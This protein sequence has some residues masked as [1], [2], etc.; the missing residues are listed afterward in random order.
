M[1][2]QSTSSSQPVVNTSHT[3]NV[4]H[5]SQ[6]AYIKPQQQPDGHLRAGD[7]ELAASS[8]ARPCVGHP[9]N[10]KQARINQGQ[11]AL[12]AMMPRSL[13][14]WCGFF[15]PTVSIDSGNARPHDGC[16]VPPE[17]ALVYHINHDMFKKEAQTLYEQQ[18]EELYEND[19][20][21]QRKLPKRTIALPRTSQHPRYFQRQQDHRPPS[22]HHPI[23]NE[24][25]MRRIDRPDSEHQSQS[26]AWVEH[27]EKWI[28]QQNQL[29]ILADLLNDQAWAFEC[30]KKEVESKDEQLVKMR[31]KWQRQAVEEETVLT[32]NE[33]ANKSN[34][35]MMSVLL[36]QQADLS[37]TVALLTPMFWELRSGGYQEKVLQL[38][39]AVERALMKKGFQGERYGSGDINEALK[40]AAAELVKDNTLLSLETRHGELS[41]IV[42]GMGKWINGD[43]YKM[44]LTEAVVPARDL[45]IQQPSH[46][47]IYASSLQGFADGFNIG[48]FTGASAIRAKKHTQKLLDEQF[49]RGFHSAEAILAKEVGLQSQV[50]QQIFEEARAVSWHQCVVYHMFRAVGANTDE[51]DQL[52]LKYAEIYGRLFSRSCYTPAQKFFL[53]AKSLARASLGNWLKKHPGS[54]PKGDL[55]RYFEHIVKEVERDRQTLDPKSL[56]GE[57]PLDDLPKA[58][59]AIVRKGRDAGLTAPVLAARF[60]KDTSQ[61]AWYAARASSSQTDPS[62]QQ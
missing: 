57:L 43:A 44:Y 7:G 21:E 15:P 10:G 20:R 56:V 14:Q 29:D 34:M 36:Q 25:H 1:N 2:F 59:Q 9:D 61:A 19:Q 48:F 39:D 49:F 5:T 30:L 31:D 11:Q 16:R 37:K 28:A 22:F 62:Q 47:A 32:I 38:R 8:N 54:D 35:A 17:G 26:D 33:A 46:P 41:K 4:G 50:W 55:T 12:L 3:S 51:H 40:K 18:I 27:Q 24:P 53:Q 42:D 6:A 45:I 58:A 13:V 60:N 23:L 52:H